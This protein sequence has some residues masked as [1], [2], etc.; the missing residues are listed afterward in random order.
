MNHSELHSSSTGEEAVLL[1]PRQKQ[2][3]DLLLQGCSNLEKAHFNPSTVFS[4]ALES[5]TESGA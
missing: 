3:T 4:C 5:L 1:S 2:I